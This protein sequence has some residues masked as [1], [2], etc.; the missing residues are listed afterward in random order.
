VD[1]GSEA[2]HDA[3]GDRHAEREQQHER[4]DRDFRRA[5]KARG[6]DANQRLDARARDHEA[7][8]ATHERE[9]DAFGQEL[10]QQAS[11]S[12]AERRADRKLAAPCFG[13]REQ[14]VGQVRARDQQYEA[15]RDLQHPDGAAGA[16]DDFLLHRLHLED[17]AKSGVR[18]LR[19]GVRWRRREDVVRGAD[20]LA[21]VPD[22][23]GQLG[24]RRRLGDAVLQPPDQ[25]EDVIA[26]ILAIG[27]IQAER[28]PDLGAVVHHIQARRHDA[29]H[30]E[31]AAVDL[32]RLSHD[33]L[34]TEGRLPQLV[35]EDRDPRRNQWRLSR[36]R[37]RSR[38]VGLARAEQTALRSLDAEGAQQVVVYLR[39]SHAQGAVAGRQVD[40][41]GR[42][43]AN[44][45]KRRVE[46]AELHVLRR[47]DPEL[48]EPEGRELGCQ[49]HQLIG[50]RI[51]ERA[52]DHGID[53]REDGGVR[54]DAQRQRQDRDEGEGRRAQQAPDRVSKVLAKMIKGHG[55]PI[56]Y[57][58]PLRR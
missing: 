32:D 57:C 17:V 23:C 31:P 47:R 9:Q 10:A 52:K 38:D 43:R 4:I 1:Q 48:V 20:P 12:G 26:A 34:A 42:V 41:A 56:V 30:F 16:A 29:E 27:G 45:R 50:I 7:E 13:A 14:Q 36:R 2:E 24:L 39:R 15:D 6:I 25:V 33:G 28:Q 5:R 54:A 49:V 11:A 3:G 8:R 35:R 46:L 44:R 58:A 18:L 37:R 22:E 21:P 51:A 19:S 40:L 55:R 53:D